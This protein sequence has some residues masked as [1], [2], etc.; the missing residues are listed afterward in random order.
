MALTDKQQAFVSEYLIDLCATKAAIRA[1]YSPKTAD[2]QGYQLLHKTAVREAIARAQAERSRRT[3][4]SADRVI[5]EL[6]RVAFVNPTDVLDLATAEVKSGANV[7]D[8]TVIA[9][10]KVK[11]VPHKDY[12]EDGEPVYEQAIEREV[13]LCD[14]L[15]AL[16]MLCRHLGMYDG[17]GNGD[18][19]ADGNGG[20]NP[21][22]GVVLMPA[23]M[24]RPE[25]PQSI[26]EVV[27]DDT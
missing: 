5:Q 8:L 18:D 27:A 21:K 2:T 13:K 20:N 14:K 22:H 3:G 6:A 24:D 15:K 7:D 4:V 19:S 11:Y 12:D 23:V 10:V 1:G 9:G 25:P 26:P 16:D 17:G